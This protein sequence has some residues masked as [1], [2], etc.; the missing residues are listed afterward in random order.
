MT[1]AIMWRLIAKPD[2]RGWYAENGEVE[3]Y[4]DHEAAMYKARALTDANDKIVF[5]SQPCTKA[6]APGALKAIPIKQY[7]RR[8]PL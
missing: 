8:K 5:V 1:Y 7:T 6:P 2:V 4:A 3:T